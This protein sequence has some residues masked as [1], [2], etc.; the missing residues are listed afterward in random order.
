MDHRTPLIV[1][2]VA[3][4]EPDLNIG[5]YDL[6]HPPRLLLFNRGYDSFY[7][8]VN[9]PCKVY[10]NLFTVI[11]LKTYLGTVFM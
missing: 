5:I 3:M 8:Y 11:G 6:S 9:C 10:S 1:D 2:H 7:I 4:R